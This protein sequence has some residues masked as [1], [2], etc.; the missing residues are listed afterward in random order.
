[1][2]YSCLVLLLLLVACAGLKPLPDKTIN[3]VYL[4]V[5]FDPIS[6]TKEISPNLSLTVKPID[7]SSLN[8]ITYN[9]VFRAGDYEREFVRE[10][11]NVERVE[12]LSSSDRRYLENLREKTYHIQDLIASGEMSEDIGF[13]LIERMWSGRRVG[14]DGSEIDLIT[15][16]KMSA[17]YN[18]YYIGNNYLSVFKIFFENNSNQLK[19]IKFD[20]FQIASGYEILIPFDVAYF[21]NRLQDDQIKLENVYRYNLTDRLNIA[22]NQKVEKYIAVPAINQSVENLSVQYIDSTGEVISFSFNVMPER[23]QYELTLKNFVIDFNSPENTRNFSNTFYAIQFENGFTF[24]LLDNNFYV[25][26]DEL[27]TNV[28]ICATGITRILRANNEL[29]CRELDLSE[30]IYSGYI[31]L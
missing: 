10:Y 18:P 22:P 23:K 31:K 5:E 9:A 19:T 17:A 6:D 20:N 11:F 4:N 16:S 1:M 7:A 12:N 21:E 27:R 24:P 3:H 13:Q 8:S 2:R 14:K 30:Y 25:S 26:R 29:K 28:T 15:G